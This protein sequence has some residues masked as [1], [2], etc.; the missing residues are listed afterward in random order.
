LALNGDDWSASHPGCFLPLYW[1][2]R[3]QYPFDRRL[4]G[5]RAGLDAVVKRKYP[6]PC[7]KSNSS[8]PAHSLVTM[9]TELSQLQKEIRKVTNYQ[10]ASSVHN[11]FQCNTVHKNERVENFTENNN[12][13]F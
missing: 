11:I 2:K 3:P 4:G 5:H 12:F 7:W 8:H 13:V 6:Y 1:G 10:I 9:L